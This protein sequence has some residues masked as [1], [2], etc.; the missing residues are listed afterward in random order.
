M[1]NFEMSE[2]GKFIKVYNVPGYVGDKGFTLEDGTINH[3]DSMMIFVG[4]CSK[5]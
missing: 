2:K 4:S 3:K 1:Y 5:I